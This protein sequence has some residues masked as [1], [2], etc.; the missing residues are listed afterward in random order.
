MNC[1]THNFED[2][3]I[4]RAFADIEQGFYVN[5][6]AFLPVADSNTYGLYTSNWTGIA[7]EPNVSEELLKMWCET[8]SGD[9]LLEKAVSNESGDLE[10][11]V[12][13]A[14]QISTGSKASVAYW[15]ENGHEP[16]H[17]KT[18]AQVTLNTIIEAQP[19]MTD[20]HL[21]YIDVEGMEYDVLQG[22][23]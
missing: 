4:Q 23:N 18:V 11:H 3:L 15:K 7:I 21:L 9:V 13:N 5:V 20:W 16:T 14:G 2:V 17:V 19:D 8:C 12:F 10:F 22:L 1:Y 6:G